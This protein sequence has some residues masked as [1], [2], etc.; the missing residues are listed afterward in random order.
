MV[1]CS[2]DCAWTLPIAK[3]FVSAGITI[4]SAATHATWD[5][6]TINIIDTPGYVVLPEAIE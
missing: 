3:S 5:G 4:A 6:N 1:L 2:D